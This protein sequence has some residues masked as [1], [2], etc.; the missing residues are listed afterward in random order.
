MMKKAF[1]LIELLIVVAIIAI[2]AAIAVPNFLESQTRAKVS[3]AMADMRTIA[4]AIEAYTVDYNRHPLDHVEWLLLNP[5]A[6]TESSALRHAWTLLQ[7]TTPVAYLTSIP[8]DP[9]ALRGGDL[10]THLSYMTRQGYGEIRNYP[11]DPSAIFYGPRSNYRWLL[12]S[13]GPDSLLEYSRGSPIIAPPELQWAG[14]V[15]YYD[16]SNGSKSQGDIYYYGPGGGV[17]P[18]PV[19]SR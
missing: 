15:V 13:R 6:G 1:T 12:E 7:L 17:N 3:R 8:Q 5:P 9:F 11:S 4:T 2:L 10:Y 16:A 14:D 19:T 18:G